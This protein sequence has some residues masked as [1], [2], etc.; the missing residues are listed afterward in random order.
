MK[1]LSM[2]LLAGV[3]LPIKNHA[4]LLQEEGVTVEWDAR[5]LNHEGEAQSF[6][7]LD[8]V[9]TPQMEYPEKLRVLDLS[10]NR[11]E[12]LPQTM[13][14]WRN[15]RSLNLM[16][17]GLTAL[18]QSFDALIHLQVLYLKGNQFDHIPLVICN[19]SR[20]SY[21]DMSHNQISFVP[22]QLAAMVPLEVLDLRENPISAISMAL[23]FGNRRLFFPVQF[24]WE[25]VTVTH[26]F[27]QAQAIWRQSPVSTGQV[28]KA[29]R[30]ARRQG[31]SVDHFEGNVTQ[32]SLEQLR[33]WLENFPVN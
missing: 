7:G 32:D 31:Q 14:Q 29:W 10:H 11:I 8:L 15:L 26:L 1:I 12:R 16:D 20:L 2:A 17:N 25:R 22:K 6:R 24:Q 19:L 23:V 27:Q 28:I 13:G 5:V 4:S 18:P 30:K 21:L 33:I 3:L 9:F